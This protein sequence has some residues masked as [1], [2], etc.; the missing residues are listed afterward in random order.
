[1]VQYRVPQF[2]Q[3]WIDS[4]WKVKGMA[5]HSALFRVPHI[6]SLFH[7]SISKKV[8]LTPA[9]KEVTTPLT[10][11]RIS[12]DHFSTLQPLLTTTNPICNP[13]KLN[14]LRLFHHVFIHFYHMFSHN[15]CFCPCRTRLWSQLHYRLDKHSTWWRWKWELP[16]Y[17]SLL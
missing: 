4:S 5:P 13:Q 3:C 14:C 12:G 6:L 8:L 15:S 16:L 2:V 11:E 9:I 17:G 10:F 7:I 1:M